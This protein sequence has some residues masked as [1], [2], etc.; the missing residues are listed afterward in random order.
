MTHVFPNVFQW[1]FFF[2]SRIMETSL[3]FVQRVGHIISSRQSPGTIKVLTLLHT[4]YSLLFLLHS[5]QQQCY[6]HQVDLLIAAYQQHTS[7]D[8]I[9]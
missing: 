6:Q 5:V 7:P 4:M 9:T 1:H 3:V 2:K 8:I